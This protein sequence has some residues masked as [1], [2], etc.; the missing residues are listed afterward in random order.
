VNLPKLTFPEYSFK[1]QTLQTGGQS[2]KI[3]DII[4]RKFVNLTPEEWVRQHLLHYLVNER[5]FPSS[6]LSVEKKLMVN[7]LLKRTDVVAYTSSLKPVMLAECKAPS[8]KLDQQVFDQAARY[9]FSLGLDYYL[10]TNGLEIICCRVD[11]EKKSY[12][13]L[14]TIPDYSSLL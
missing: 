2:L 12:Q 14:E 6:L 10:I 11:R 7:R 1:L 5:K 9:N 3:F 4:R 13:F 8:V